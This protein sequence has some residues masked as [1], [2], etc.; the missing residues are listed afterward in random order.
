MISAKKQKQSYIAGSGVSGPL[1][2]M[3]GRTP[4]P[5]PRKHREV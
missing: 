4:L 5:V 2:Q 3:G 1:V